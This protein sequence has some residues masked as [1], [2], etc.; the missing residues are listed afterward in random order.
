MN[1]TREH[2]PGAVLISYGEIAARAE[3]ELPDKNQL[4]LV[5]SVAVEE[6]KLQP[7]SL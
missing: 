4:I 2:I 5:Y 7:R 6:A 1:M 3:K